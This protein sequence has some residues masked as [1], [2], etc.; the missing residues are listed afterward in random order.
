MSFPKRLYPHLHEMHRLCNG[1]YNNSIVAQRYHHVHERA[2]DGELDKYQ[3]TERY[4]AEKCGTN[5][6]IHKIDDNIK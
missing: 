2:L 6:E 3:R 4:R 5:K 1:D